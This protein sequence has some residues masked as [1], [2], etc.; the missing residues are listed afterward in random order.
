MTSS[1]AICRG[2]ICLA[3]G[4]GKYGKLGLEL[5]MGN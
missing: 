2:G 4:L 1:F 5:S 3:W